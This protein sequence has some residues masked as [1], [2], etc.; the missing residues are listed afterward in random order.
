M[1]YNHRVTKSQT[2]LKQLNMHTC[3]HVNMFVYTNIGTRKEKFTVH[4]QVEMKKKK[5]ERQMD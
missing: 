1:S 2:Q 3:I 4:E 5:N